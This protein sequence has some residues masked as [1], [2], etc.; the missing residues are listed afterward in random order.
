MA[1][2]R[3]VDA[4]KLFN[5]SKSIAGKHVTLRSAQL[6]A[7]SKT[8]TL[9]KAAKKQTDRVTLTAQAAIALSQ[10]L[11]EDAPLYAS[12]AASEASARWNGDI[13]RKENLRA[14]QPSEDIKDGLEQDHHYDRSGSNSVADPPAKGELDL[15]QEKAQRR[16]LPDG[17]I[18]P[19]GSVLEEGNQGREPIPARHAELSPDEAR[20]LQRQAEA[21]IPSRSDE[22]IQ[23]PQSNPRAEELIEGHDRDVFYTRSKEAQPEPS[24][25]PR[26]KIPKHTE[27]KQNSDDRV[28][29]GRIN[30]DVYYATPEPG[31]NA[32]QHEVLPHQAAVPEQDQ[33][34]EGVNTDVFRTTRV[35]K[36]LGV[37]P[38]E[39][40]P[41]LDLK[42]A[43]RTPHD[44][45]KTALGHDQDSFNV[46]SSEQ[47]K[48]SAPEQPAQ[49]VP[50]VQKP[51]EQEMHDLASDL[52]KDAAGIASPVSEVS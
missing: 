10:R 41:A 22:K 51:T 4:A 28:D 1:G 34:P 20:S 14:E 50:D 35:A 13:P 11:N 25:L 16:P 36:M 17:T 48:P 18:P 12:A 39:S 44:R 23:P 2:R 19:P 3:L 47:S 45:T 31:Q 32:P 7:F 15:H 21:Q 30:Q 5:A 49:D 42:G 9:A 6:D 26:T 43:S 46:R 27:N 24:S 29:T 40:K 8:S 37:H 33:I 38:K 52:A